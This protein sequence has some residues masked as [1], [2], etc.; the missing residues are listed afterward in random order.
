MGGRLDTIQAAV[1]NV[2]LKYYEKDLALRQKVAQKY[3]ELLKSKNQL[4]KTPTVIHDRNSAWAQYSIRIKNREEVQNKLK[5]TGVPTAVHYPIPL[6]LQECFSYLGYQKGD[7]P[8]SE[9]ISKEILSLP[10]NPYMKDEDLAYIVTNLLE[11]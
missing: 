11:N 5:D 4:L 9:T 6:H 3:T 2:K 8:I 1:L 10:I 7:F